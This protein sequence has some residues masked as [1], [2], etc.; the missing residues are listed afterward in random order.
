MTSCD[1]VFSG[2]RVIDGQGSASRFIDVVVDRERIVDLGDCR[3]WQA[4][5]IIDASGLALAPGFIDSHTHD[6][7]AIFKSP[8]VE[9]KISQGVTTVIA[10][11][12]G[13]SLAPLIPA[14]T[15]PAPFPLLGEPQEFCFPTVKDYRAALSRN[16]A[17][18]NLALLAGHSSLRLGSMP[19]RLE[20]TADTDALQQMQ[21]DL[22]L[23]LQQGCIGL[24]TGL[25]YPPAASASTD[26]VIQLASVLPEF[27][28]SVFATHMRDEGD[29][30]LEAIEETLVIGKRA[31]VPVIISHHK[32]AGPNNYGRSRQTLELIDQAR[33]E[34]QPVSFD[35]YPYIAS[36]TSLLPRFIENCEA[37]MVAESKPHP[38]CNGKI[39]E[40]IAADWKCSP[41]QACERLYPAS[42]IYFQMDESDLQRIMAHP[43]AMIGSDGI[44]S[45]QTPH[46][47]LWGTF[48]RV[49]GHYVRQK[50]LFDLETAVHK[51]T[52]LTASRFGLENRGS[53]EIGNYADLVLFDPQTIIDRASFENPTQISDGIVSVWVNGKLGWHENLPGG[54]R[55]GIFLSH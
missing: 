38:E 43:G 14:D 36:S 10:G 53:I 23:A 41:E 50:K 3:H 48:P 49:L 55:S 24:S 2:A 9:F 5:T 26:E 8:D 4:D 1:L 16:P 52:G 31:Q 46:P 27:K 28:N 45:M 44:A 19:D 32:C 12:C 33:S 39:L 34:N 7:L 17:A 40:Q 51:M 54:A 20:H 21:Q 6:D 35:V 42:A 13:L 22:R 15:M 37:V 18:V 25:D 29:R 47:R 11:N 30:V